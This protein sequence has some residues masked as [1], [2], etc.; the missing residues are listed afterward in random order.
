MFNNHQS[1]IK[2]SEIKLFCVFTLIYLL[3]IVQVVDFG[4]SFSNSSHD[5]LSVLLHLGRAG[6]QVLPVGE[7]GL[8]LWVHHQHPVD[9]SSHFLFSGVFHGFVNI[10]AVRVDKTRLKISFVSWCVVQL[11]SSVKFKAAVLLHM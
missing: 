11:I 3:V 1:I 4:H 8:G 10:V 6:A 5:G 9:V 2:E 7:I